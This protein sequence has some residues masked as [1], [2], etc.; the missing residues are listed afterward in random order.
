MSIVTEFYAP[1]GKAHDVQAIGPSVS[2][3]VCT[4]MRPESLERFLRSLALQS[5]PFNDCVII[6]ASPGDSTELAVREFLQSQNLQGPLRYFRVAGS[7]TGLTRQRNFALRH[8]TSEL[9]GFF[10]D[11]VLLEPGCLSEMVRVHV[12]RGSEVVAVGACA[13]SVDVSQ[14]RLWK[15]RR[16]LHII[17]DLRPGSYQRSGMSV[18]WEFLPA[19]NNAVEGDWLGGFAMMWKTRIIQELGFR[20]TFGGYAQGEDLDVSL[21]ARHQ[22]KLL[23]AGAARVRHLHDANG[24]PDHYNLGYMAIYNRYQ[25]H[26]QGLSDRA[27][28]DIAWFTYA[29]LMDS[30]LLAR[31]FFRPAQIIPT[32]QQWV[33]RAKASYDLVMSRWRHEKA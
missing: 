27:W 6:D 28:R 19:T 10:D 3:V 22:G 23:M 1:P 25:I 18:P 21:R 20:E 13:G 17:S 8:I 26:R 2:V 24:R 30:I 4:F 11:D 7:D 12:E 33:G 31:Q 9:V 32:M 16:K 5:M 14:D 29:W 15:L